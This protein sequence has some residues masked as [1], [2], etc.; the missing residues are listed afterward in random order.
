MRNHPGS[1]AGRT[2]K[3][4]PCIGVIPVHHPLGFRYEPGVFGPNPEMRSLDAIRP[5]LRNPDCS[6]PDPVYAI[7][8]DVGRADVRPQLQ[9]RM[10][11]FGAV[12][13]AS[14]QLG[15]EPVRSQGHVHHISSHSGWAP[16][17][18]YE[19]WEGSAFVYM[20][21]F[22]ADNPGRCYAILAKPGNKVVV[23]PAWAHAAISA[24]TSDFMA[25]GALCDREY[26][27]DYRAVRRRKGLAW[28][29]NVTRDGKIEWV[30]N[31]RYEKTILEVRPPREYREFGFVQ[32]NSLYEQA[33]RDLDRFAWVS[34]PVMCEE[35]WKHFEP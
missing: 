29:P 20:Q 31:P 33:A 5:S 8:M 14:G 35:V 9:Q 16:P 6:G 30:P 1:S 28:Y 2:M 12:I 26:S 18:I 11:L 17:E 4:D 34:K 15:E 22:V 25:L 7:V 27:F 3:F 32:E 13:Y 10:L 23:P 19:I 24:D 21:E